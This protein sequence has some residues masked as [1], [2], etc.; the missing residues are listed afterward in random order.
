MRAI[1]AELGTARPNFGDLKKIGEKLWK[2]ADVPPPGREE[3]RRR[4]IFVGWLNSNEALFEPFLCDVTPVPA[5][6]E[7]SEDQGDLPF[8][9]YFSPLFE[10][11]YK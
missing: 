2:L 11:D 10:N 5:T 3:K 9:E 7:P 6:L 4:D 1:A 8:D